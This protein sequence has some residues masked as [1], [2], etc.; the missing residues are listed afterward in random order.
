MIDR[1][2]EEAYDDEQYFYSLIDAEDEDDGDDYAEHNTHSYAASG[3]K[4]S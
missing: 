4:K 2:R 3:V 1:E